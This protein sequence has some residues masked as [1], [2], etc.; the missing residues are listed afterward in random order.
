MYH[1]D[2]SSKNDLYKSWVIGMELKSTNVW[3]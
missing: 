2:A 3:N 1:L